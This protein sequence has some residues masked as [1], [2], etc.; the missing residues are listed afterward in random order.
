MFFSF[1]SVFASE[2][3]MQLGFGC[4]RVYSDTQTYE[5]PLVVEK[6]GFG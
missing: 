4:S 6:S 2:G 5:Q 1:C 3:K